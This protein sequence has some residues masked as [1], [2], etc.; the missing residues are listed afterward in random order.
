VQGPTGLA[1]L[2][3]SHTL[4]VTDNLAAGP[5]ALLQGPAD[6]AWPRAA[7]A[8]FALPPEM[9]VTTAAVVVTA[10]APGEADGLLIAGTSRRPGLLR[11]AFGPAG[12]VLSTAWIATDGIDGAILALVVG[13]D[14]AVYACTAQALVRIGA[15][16]H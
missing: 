3:R 2:G 9:G 12:D 15:T 10:L 5:S 16:G 13:A 11:L 7:R 1:W 8:R 4:W 14:G 6:A